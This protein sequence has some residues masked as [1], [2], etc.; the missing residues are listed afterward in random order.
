MEFKGTKGPWHVNCVLTNTSG[1]ADIKSV[2]NEHIIACLAAYEFRNAT[3]EET[4]ANAKLISK[5]PEMLEMLMECERTL[6]EIYGC[7][8]DEIKNLIKEATEI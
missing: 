5:A 7:D 6:Q 4:N 8:T 1:I 3:I 2:Y